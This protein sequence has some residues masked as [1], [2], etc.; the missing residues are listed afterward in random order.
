MIKKV[1]D[2]KGDSSETSK[3]L[4]GFSED[5]IADMIDDAS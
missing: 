3:D 2:T 1:F 5:D 4:G